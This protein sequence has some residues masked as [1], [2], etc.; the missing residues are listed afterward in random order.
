MTRAL[1]T[2]PRLA[3]AATVTTASQ[4][5]AKAVDPYVEL[6]RVVA[7]R[8]LLERDPRRQL[9]PGAG[10]ILLLAVVVAGVAFT[11]GTWWVLL[12]AAPAALLFGQIGF[13]AHDAT[14]NQILNT[15]RANYVLSVLLFNL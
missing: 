8:G 12:L 15:S 7:E 14:H 10:H 3:E 9:L 2:S 1:A 13:L 4:P 6:K 5:P 11:R